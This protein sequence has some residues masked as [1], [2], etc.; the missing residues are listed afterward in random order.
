MSWREEGELRRFGAGRGACGG[1]FGQV[2]GDSFAMSG[3]CFAQGG[4]RSRVSR[5]SSVVDRRCSLRSGVISSAAG[6]ISARSVPM[7]SGSGLISLSSET[8][9]PSTPPASSSNGDSS[10]SPASGKSAASGD[11]ED[12]PPKSADLLIRVRGLSKSYKMGNQLV[13]ALQEVDLDIRRNEYVAV[14]GPSGSGKSTFMNLIGCLDVPTSGS[15][16][17]N[18]QLV[19]GL[20]E[21]A[22]AGIRN[23]EIGFVF[24]TF[25]LLPRA[26]ALANV[27]L[28]LVYAGVSKA[29]RRRRAVEVL[30]RVGLAE[31][32]D[33]RPNELSGGQRQRVAIAR[34]LVTEPALLLADEPTGALDTRT[35]E[36]IM[37]LFNQLHSQGQTVMVVTHEAEIAE[38]ALRLVSL[39]DGRI[40]QDVPTQ[41]ARGGNS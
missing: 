11:V 37:E 24:Q 29:E 12:G 20:S 8:S 28:P 16:W 2:V 6:V 15:Y 26:T 39:R 25:H 5:T 10:S 4:V 19:S 40:E 30:E 41:R 35:G 1:L 36:E 38:H 27:A 33:H 7:S 22:L 9:S 31:R 17:L 23:R 21:D 13:H 3:S 14:M 18:H 34:A 32:M